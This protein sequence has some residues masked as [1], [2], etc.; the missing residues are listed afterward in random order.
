MNTGQLRAASSV[1]RAPPARGEPVRRRQAGPSPSSYW[2][3]RRDSESRIG[4][5]KGPRPGHLDDPAA[6]LITHTRACPALD[7]SLVTSNDPAPFAEG[8]SHTRTNVQAAR[9]PEVFVRDRGRRCGKPEHDQRTPTGTAHVSESDRALRRGAGQRM[10]LCRRAECKPIA[11]GC[12]LTDHP[13]G[14]R[15]DIPEVTHDRARKRACP[16][17]G[18]RFGAQ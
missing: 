18:G 8:L 3:A 5:R 7:R 10:Q 2:Y 4:A 13:R 11:M 15:N 12:C 1:T 9:S 17:K 14:N 6:G 16:R